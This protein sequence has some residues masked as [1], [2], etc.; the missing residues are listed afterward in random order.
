MNLNLN[1]ISSNPYTNATH[2]IL[3]DLRQQLITRAL[4]FD[5]HFRSL[6]TES[7]MSLHKMFLNTYGMMYEQ[8]TDIFAN[9]FDSLEQYYATG[10]VPLTKSMESF[11]ERLYQKIFQVVN[12]NRIF[13]A[14]YLVC[15]T[16][17]LAHLKPFKDAPE[18]LIVD[19][20]HALVA[21]RTFNQALNSAIDIIKS[22]ISV[23]DP[24]LSVF[25]S[26]RNRVGACVVRI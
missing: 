7:K 24:Y 3:L 9:M 16:E 21:A 20:R 5:E 12:R 6:L 17:Q 22:I 19:I 23:S 2:T 13:P 26:Y 14:N 10:Q 8:N 18:K 15:A 4:K 1:L 25:S 11:F